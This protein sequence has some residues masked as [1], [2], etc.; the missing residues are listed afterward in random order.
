MAKLTIKEIAKMAGV[1]PTAV[2]FVL[3]NKPGISEDTRRRI[4]DIITK[5]RYTPSRASRSL[6]SQCSYNIAFLFAHNASPFNDMFYW[7]LAKNVSD[8][9]TARGYRMVL[10]ESV[11]DEEGDRV[12]GVILEKDV[13][14][15]ICFQG[16]NDTVREVLKDME[17]PYVVLDSHE[18][19]GDICVYA[20]YRKMVRAS[21]G[22]LY[23][24]GFRN[25][26]VILSDSIVGY[27][28]AFYEGYEQA[29]AE[30]GLP[31][32]PYMAEKGANDPE[33]AYECMRRILATGDQPDAVI[34]S[35]DMYAIGAMKCAR[36]AGL[37]IPEDISFMGTDDIPMSRYSDPPLTTVRTDLESMARCGV[38]MVMRLIEGEK[39]ESCVIRSDEIIERK[40]VGFG[41]YA[42]K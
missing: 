17:I 35:G 29:L 30:H 8:L 32:K 33:S 7:S 4:Q 42:G 28:R 19:S 10:A 3:N 39:V 24:R 27:W 36:D 25:I 11:T 6:V 38:D 21:F 37:R 15:I 34:C 16:V 26:A 23:N 13:D 20:D 1:S 9:C 40:S 12:P 18:D 5:M 22:Y 14:G 31:F 41:K 2:S